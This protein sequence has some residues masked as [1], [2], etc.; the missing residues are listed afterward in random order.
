MKSY[1]IRVP[2]AGHVDVS[3]DTDEDEE[4]AIE[5]A[6]ERAD[7]AYAWDREAAKKADCENGELCARRA[8]AT[9]NVSHVTDDRVRVLSVESDD[10]DGEDE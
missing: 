4:K 5:M 8:L 7:N 1:F 6:I 10:V 2:I 3:V 9:G